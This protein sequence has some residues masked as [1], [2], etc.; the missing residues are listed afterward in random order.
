VAAYRVVQEALTNV[1]R[2][3]AARRAEVALD[4]G[5]DALVVTVSDDGRGGTGASGP[6]RP[7]GHGLAGM[8]E[9]VTIL[10][11]SLDAGPRAEGGFAVRARLP[12]ASAQR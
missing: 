2:H 6:D 1:L 11:G 9:R 3:A 7:S 8:R 10:G 12:L 5:P 4:Y